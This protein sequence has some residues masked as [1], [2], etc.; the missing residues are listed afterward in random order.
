MDENLDWEQVNQCTHEMVPF[1]TTDGVETRK[2]K[3]CGVMPARAEPDSVIHTL[4]DPFNK[5][6]ARSMTKPRIRRGVT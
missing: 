2:C 1:R 4:P 3:L 6:P 5:Q